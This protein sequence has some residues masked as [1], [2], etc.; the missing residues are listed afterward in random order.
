MLADAVRLAVQAGDLATA[1]NLA[2]QA[3]ALAAGSE[4]PHRLAAAA[5]CRAVLNH[6]GPALVTAA[7]RYEAARRPPCGAGPRGRRRR[8]PRRR[9]SC[10]GPG[11]PHPRCQHLHSSLGATADVSRLLARFRA[12]GVRLGPRS[13]HRR[14]D[15][16]W[17]SLTPTEAKIA[18]FVQDG[19]SNPE[20]AARLLLSRR[21]VA[22]HVSHILAKL[23]ASRPRSLASQPCVPWRR[24]DPGAGITAAFS[25]DS[26]RAGNDSESPRLNPARPGA[27]HTN[28]LPPVP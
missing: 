16:G 13:R 19:L 24:G 8:A 10:G 15:D 14:A 7:E 4:I 22:T 28:G 18:A 21:T 3:A 1:R 27:N 9:R 11:R 25:E 12:R 6:D 23:G 20:I 17:D 2:G 5:Y 26:E